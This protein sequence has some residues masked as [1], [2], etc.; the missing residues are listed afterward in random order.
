MTLCV[1][2]RESLKYESSSSDSKSSK[3]KKSSSSASSASGH[4]D[5]N[6]GGDAMKEFVEIGLSQLVDSLDTLDKSALITNAPLYDNYWLKFSEKG[7][8]HIVA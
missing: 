4:N 6:G 5:T 7:D 1:V 3:K 8:K 2:E